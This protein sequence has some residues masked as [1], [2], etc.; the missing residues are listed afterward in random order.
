MKKITIIFG[1]FAVLVIG[2][3]W[4]MGHFMMAYAT[5]PDDN[6]GKDY[7]LT[8]S[9]VY[10][11]YP[12]LQQ[13]HDSLVSL[14]LWRDTMLVNADGLKLHGIIIEQGDSARGSMMMIHGYCD[15]AP[16]MM[17]YAYCD[18][19]ELG[20]N[21]LLPERQNC[22]KSEGDFITFG[23]LDH[24]DMHLWAELMHN[25]WPD[26]DLWIHGLSMGAATTMMMSGDEWPD[27]LQVKGFIEDCGY[28]STWDQLSFQLEDQ[29]G[30]AAFP[31]LY[32][33]SIA[34]FNHNGY[35]F[36]EGDAKSQV[37]KS[38]KPMLFIHGEN[39]DFVPTAMAYECFEAKTTGYKE[40]WIAPGSRHAKS[41]HDHYQEYVS[42]MAQF[43][44]TCAIIEQAAA[45]TL[46]VA[47]DTL[48]IE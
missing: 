10:G 36:S 27:S 40:L 9:M 3:L 38:T 48:T 5:R 25:T 43:I 17:R 20:M 7:D 45:D 44:D 42:H 2:T 31:A 18:Y 41:I 47:A 39:D 6:Y 33:A 15:N 37:A 21:V 23:W 34:S 19:H 8:Y 26:K 14:N 11:K 30:M 13:W 28:S 29:F 12:E 24:W 1:I 46:S 16:V 32:V 35:I 4:A 22:G